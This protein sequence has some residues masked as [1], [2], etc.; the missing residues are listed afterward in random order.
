MKDK[1][2]IPEEFA[3]IIE[4][5]NNVRSGQTR[6]YGPYEEVYIVILKKEYDACDEKDCARILDF[7]QK[8][9]HKCK[10]TQ[11]ELLTIKQARDRSFDEL[12]S[13][14][15]EGSYIL[16]HDFVDKKMVKYIWSQD[17]LD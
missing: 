7:C 1:I 2:E 16:R 11:Q 9:C 17:Y 5:A 4:S 10:Y 13:A 6:R 12:M 8:H 3:D 14:V 15:V